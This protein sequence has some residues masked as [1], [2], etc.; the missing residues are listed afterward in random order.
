MSRNYSFRVPAGTS[1]LGAGFDAL[2]LA[3]EIYLR[4][5]IEFPAKM[6]VVALGVLLGDLADPR[7][8]LHAVSAAGEGIRICFRF[9][10][11]SFPFS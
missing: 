6:E 2:G 10:H 11:S 8:S 3:L 4:V 5:R 7:R 1:N 9:L